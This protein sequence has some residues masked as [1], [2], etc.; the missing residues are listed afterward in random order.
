MNASHDLADSV[1]QARL[2]RSGGARDDSPSWNLGRAKQGDTIRVDDT[3]PRG[4][5]Q[6]SV[7]EC[8]KHEAKPLNESAA[9]CTTK[10]NDVSTTRLPGNDESLTI[11][12]EE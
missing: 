9:E 4:R 5:G 11:S 8:S 12:E 10:G 7:S 3:S 2:V 1:D 6:G